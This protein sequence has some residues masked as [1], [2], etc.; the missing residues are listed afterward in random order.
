MRVHRGNPSRPLLILVHGLGVT[1]RTWTDPYLERMGRGRIPFDYLLVDLKHTPLFRWNDRP[2]AFTTSTPWH[3]LP[4]RPK[5]FWEDLA[6][7]GYN[8]L[9]WSQKDPNGPINTAV[10]E[11][12]EVWEEARKI[13]GEKRVIFLCHSRG[14]LIVR[15]Y[16]RK[17][18]RYREGVAAAIFLATPHYGSRIADIAEIM[19][20][21]VTSL[22]KLLPHVV[23]EEVRR[24]YNQWMDTFRTGAVEELRPHSSFI[25][26]LREW[27]KKELGMRYVNLLGVSTCVNKIYRIVREN[28]FEVKE[29]F[30]LLDPSPQPPFPSLLPDEWV[31]GQGDGLVARARGKLTWLPPRDQR[32][33]SLNHAS[34]LIDSRVRELVLE[35]LEEFS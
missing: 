21:F 4:N 32:E 17:Y 2:R 29:V 3:F 10:E 7:K 15:E 35:R 14:G 11:L 20:R 34:I 22:E 5:S 31:D 25:L 27:E 24:V 33:F 23:R 1:E 9:T 18:E 6:E 13:F 16:L 8:L 30:S 19:G 28:P 12:K 26:T